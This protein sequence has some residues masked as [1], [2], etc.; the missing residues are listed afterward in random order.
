MSS[1]AFQVPS[2][3]CP[4]TELRGRQFSFEAMNLIQQP[5]DD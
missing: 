4:L 3:A 1:D 2:I 5:I